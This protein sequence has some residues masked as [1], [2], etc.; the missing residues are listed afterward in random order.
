MMK[1]VRKV[2]AF[3]LAVVVMFTLTGCSVGDLVKR[4]QHQPAIQTPDSLPEPVEEIV[5]NEEEIEEPKV[6]SIEESKEEETKD[7]EPKVEEPEVIDKEPEAEPEEPEKP[8]EIYILFTSDIH[9]GIDQN[10]GFAGLKQIKDTLEAEGYETILVDDGDA[11]QGEAIGTVTKG[12]T[13]LSLM[14]EIGYDVAIPGNHEFD[15]GMDRFLEIAKKASFPYISCN[16]NLKGDLVFEPY[17]IKEVA[18]KKIAFVGVT[19]PETLISSTPAY[20]QDENGEYIYGFMQDKTGE[21]LYKALQDAIDAAKND[22]AEYVYVMGHLG[23]EAE[24][25][26]WTYADVI[27]NTTGIDV[28]LDGHSHD[29]DKVVMKD[30]DGNEVTRVAVGTK[31]SN[32]GYSHI[33]AEGE[34]VETSSFTWNN[35]IDAPTLF[36]IKND[37]RT[38]VDEAERKL[39]EEMSKVVASSKVDLTISDPEVV[40]S[41]GKPIRIIRRTETNLGDLCADAYRDQSDADVAFVNGG[42]IRVSI[43]KGDITYGD[44]I[45]VHPFGNML[46]VIEVSG[47]QILD[48]LEWGAKGVPGENG[49]FIQVSGLTYE[50]DATIDS[51]CVEDDNS[52]FVK[53]KGKRRV[54]NV[55]VGDK[56]ID[57]KAKYTLAG[58]DY[59]LLGHGDGFTMFDG[60]TVLQDRVKIDNQV[61]IDYI[62]DTLGGTIGEEYAEPFGEGRIVIKDSEA[63]SKD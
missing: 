9:C 50:I 19:T 61:L 33:N 15:Y 7:E 10:F 21:A 60:A 14:N 40:D 1:T 47:Q 6:T 20:F 13:I 45:A 56:P 49:G 53:I 11:I 36:D 37:I 12:E 35:P 5:P 59:M 38:G 43:E 18:G 39:D 34:I 41:N 51:P 52:M 16:F 27:A 54:S 58:H 55:M 3:L 42:G 25:E 8:A 29:T 46:T 24:C 26:P 48:A 31:M 2:G 63:D 17:V 4:P 22:G 23:N 62:T 32:I 30:K 44:I 28:F 57:P